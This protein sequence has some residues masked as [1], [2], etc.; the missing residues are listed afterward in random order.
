M[1]LGWKSLIYIAI[2]LAAVFF[3]SQLLITPKK[4]TEI[5]LDEAIAMSQGDKIEKLVIEGQCK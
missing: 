3:L 1:R 2:L 4:P 5:S